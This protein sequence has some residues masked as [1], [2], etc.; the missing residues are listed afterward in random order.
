MEPPT[1]PDF[2][3][4]QVRVQTMREETFFYVACA[5]TP[6]A[7]L[8]KELDRMMP[9]LEA[10]RAAAGIAHIGAVVIRYYKVGEPDIADELH[11]YVMEAGVPV[12]AGTQAAG[13]AQV[14]TLPPYRCASLLS[15]GSLEHIGQ[16]YETLMQAIKEAGLEQTGE[17]RE[18]HY[19]FEGDASPNNVIG[20]HM[21][22]R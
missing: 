10:A 11:P 22:I 15:W 17:G 21:G 1:T 3:I 19:H 13:E 12:R 7:G 14:K 8:D 20:L 5:P 2:L 6:M 4:S 16:A 18:W 9:Q